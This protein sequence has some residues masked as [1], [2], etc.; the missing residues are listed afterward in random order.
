[1]I[2]I[3]LLKKGLYT[4]PKILIF[5]MFDKLLNEK[6]QCII[7]SGFIILFAKT[8]SNELLIFIQVHNC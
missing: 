6:K 4:V 1:M 8:K 2:K 7:G 3:L 5:V